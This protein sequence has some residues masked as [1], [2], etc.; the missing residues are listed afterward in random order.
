MT[1][2]QAK[3][4]TIRIFLGLVADDRMEIE[5]RDIAGVLEGLGTASKGQEAAA[6]G[7][8]ELV[9]ALNGDE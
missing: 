2:D 6:G 9:E 1:L 8:M 3:T 4:S 5:A 7:L